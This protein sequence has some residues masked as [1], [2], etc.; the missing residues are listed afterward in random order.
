MCQQLQC[1]LATAFLRRRAQFSTGD[2]VVLQQ[3]GLLRVVTPQMH[4]V[5]VFFKF[6]ASK[7]ARAKP[8]PNPVGPICLV[9]VLTGTAPPLGLEDSMLLL[10][11][12]NDKLSAG[13]KT[14]RP[15]RHRW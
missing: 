8:A 11:Q 14:G 5:T 1:Q 7:F 12:C 10:P 4:N 2:A 6:F 3:K 15:V 9:L 13:P